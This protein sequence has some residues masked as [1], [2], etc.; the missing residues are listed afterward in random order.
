MKGIKQHQL[1]CKTCSHTCMGGIFKKEQLEQ[2]NANKCEIDYQPGDYIVRQGSFISQVFYL[3]EGL[4][5]IVLE[6]KNNRNTIIKLVKPDN[7]FALPILGNDMQYPFSAITL[8]ESSICLI[9]KESFMQLL[10]KNNNAY[11]YLLQWYANDYLLMYSKIAT[12][13]TRNSHGK[14]ASALLYVTG[15]EFNTTV[16]EKIT[17]KDIAEL[18][19]TSL[20]SVNKILQQLN[21]DGIIET[22]KHNIVIKRRDLLEKLS[23]VG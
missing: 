22:K 8:T 23:T 4:I 10:Q 16:L 9:R 15:D 1:D 19:S 20:E 14:V 3:R 21:H 2:L 12:I 6:G 11:M 17:R 5:K 13:S 7:F 18:S